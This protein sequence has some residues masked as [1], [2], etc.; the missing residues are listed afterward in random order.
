MKNGFYVSHFR[1]SKVFRALEDAFSSLS[2]LI[3]EFLDCFF[4]QFLCVTGFLVVAV[5]VLEV[6]VLTVVALVVVLVLVLVV[7]LVVVGAAVDVVVVVVVVL[8]TGIASVVV[9][10]I[11]IGTHSGTGKSHIP[12]SI[13]DKNPSPFTTVSFIH[14]TSANVPMG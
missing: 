11:C 12:L 5:V 10:F 7:A 2:S 1:D 4:L 8:S 3:F 6:V 14:C 9:L 13:H